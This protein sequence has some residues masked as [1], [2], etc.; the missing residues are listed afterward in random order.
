MVLLERIELSTSPFNLRRAFA[1][2]WRPDYPLT[3]APES[4]LG[5]ARLVSTPS[6]TGRAWLGIG[7]GR[8]PLAFPEFERFA[9]I[10]FRL[11]RQNISPRECSTSE[12]Q[13]HWRRRY[14]FDRAPTR[15]KMPD[16]SDGREGS[17]AVVR[18]TGSGEVQRRYRPVRS[19]RLV[20][21]VDRLG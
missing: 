17:W 3:L 2:T 20:D 21:A 12:L 13:Q 4:A 11:G 6:R 18:K 10:R 16:P 8:R 14:S 19:T 7:M 1:P 9:P 15:A 5:S